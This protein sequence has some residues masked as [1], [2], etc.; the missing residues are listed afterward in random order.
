MRVCDCVCKLGE[1]YL[2]A[3]GFESSKCALANGDLI[4]VD[5]A[6]YIVS[7]VNLMKEEWWVRNGEKKMGKQ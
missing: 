7:F 4:L 2:A 1:R 6:N 5:V 3:K